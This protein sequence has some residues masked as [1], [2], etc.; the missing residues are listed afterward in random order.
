MPESPLVQKEAAALADLESLIADRVKRESDTELGFKKRIDREE[1]EYQTLAHQFGSKFKV[2]LESL[3]AEYKRVKQ[4]VLQT[5]QRDSQACD[6]EYSQTKQQIDDQFKKEQRRAKKIKEE[7]GWQALAFY[8]G[9]R[10]EGIKWRRGTESSWAG[11]IDH[12]HAYHDHAAI[13]LKRCGKLANASPEEE[14]TAMA[15]AA[16]AAASKPAPEPGAEGE[17]PAE[18]AAPPPDNPLTHLRANLDLTVRGAISIAR[19]LQDPL[20]ELVKVDPKSIGVG[21]YQHD[22]DQR[23]LAESLEATV[24]SCVNRVGVDL[25]TSSWTLLRH[26]AGI[27]ER[28]AKKL[29]EF[30]NENGRFRSRAALTA[31]PGIGPKTFEQAAGFLRIR[32]GDRTRA[33]TFRGGRPRVRSFAHLR[34][35]ARYRVLHATIFAVSM[36]FLL[37]IC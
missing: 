20:S 5:F 4:G 22:A 7:A 36:L 21:Q 18:P 31:V 12:L 6:A 14:A 34:W 30:R 1:K 29:I 3:E 8:E 24:E 13:L 17:T 28:T 35:T 2:D 15:A 16:Q 33:G 9:S 26:V 11:A 10:D 37:F 25:N 23:Q 27:N 19:R 32:G